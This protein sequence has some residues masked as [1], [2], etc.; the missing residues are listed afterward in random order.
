MTRI[1]NAFIEYLIK[2][3]VLEEEY[4]EDSIYGMTLLTEKIISCS[5]LF[6]ITVLFGRP[7]E[8]IIFIASFL[9]LRQAT[10]GFHMKTFAGC[11]L[12]SSIIILTVFGGFAPVLQTRS[13]LLNILLF[14]SAILIIVF[15]PVNHPNLMLT[16]EEKRRHKYWSIGILI[17]ELVSMEIGNAMRVPWS[18]Y[19]A[20]AIIM[21]GTFIIVAKIL[22]QEVRT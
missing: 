18:V 10:G 21:C 19:I 14:I 7:L 4:R 1:V 20:L 6:M 11:L 9:S 16:R 13:V 3:G 5:L 2:N 17:L 22:R 15:A 12:G 8:G